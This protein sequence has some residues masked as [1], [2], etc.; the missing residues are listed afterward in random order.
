MSHDDTKQFVLPSSLI[1]RNDL[2]RL[3]V[4]LEAVDNELT[5]KAIHEQTGHGHDEPVVFSKMF[6]HVIEAN[7]IDMGDPAVRAGMLQELRRL[8]DQAPV[9]HMT[10]ATTV[11]NEVLVKLISWLREKIDPQALI[12][13]GL[14]PGLIG[15]VHVRTTNKVF[16]L[17][18]R[19][20][21]ADGR[22]II[23][24]ELEA[25]NGV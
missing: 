9:V 19:S 23:L 1:T 21:L 20:Q 14:Q 4:E 10:F 18:M 7:E 6:E 12:D 24:K 22:K 11:K 17:S 2:R 25:I 5:T 13:V 15:G 8:K 3:I 16:D